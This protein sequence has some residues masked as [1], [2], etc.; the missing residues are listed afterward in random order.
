MSRELEKARVKNLPTEKIF[1]IGRYRI[2]QPKNKIGNLLDRY[3]L[4]DENENYHSINAFAVFYTERH[5]KK[6]LEGIKA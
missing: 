6:F 1:W 2:V 4:F 5:L 3:Y